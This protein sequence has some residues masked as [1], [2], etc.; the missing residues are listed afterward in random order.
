MGDGSIED[1]KKECLL[2]PPCT[3]VD[4][5]TSADTEVGNVHCYLHGNWSGEISYID[6]GQGA[7]HY[8]F[9]RT[10]VDPGNKFKSFSHNY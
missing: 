10:C 7:N 6:F 2:Y 8:S 4:Y 5:L 3:G 9:D 1:C